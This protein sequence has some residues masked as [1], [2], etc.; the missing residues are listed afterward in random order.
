MNAAM[1]D[2]PINPYQ[3]PTSDTEDG[4]DA[5]RDLLVPF[6]RALFSP[7]Q[8]A[9]ATILGTVLAGALMLQANYRAM[10]RSGAAN[11]TL[12]LG[13]VSTIAVIGLVMILPKSARSPVNL[14]LAVGFYWLCES[15]PGGLFALHR[16]EGGARHSNWL[17]L[18]IAL[19]TIVAVLLVLFAVV[20]A[21]GV[22][23]H[24]D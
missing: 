7:K 1:P 16:Q 19:A 4:Q 22:L 17:V 12:L 21:S 2:Q 23:N 6:P 11:K 9:A 3:P 18:G 15:L 5:K 8:M 14:G 24:V 10:G 20:F 13:L